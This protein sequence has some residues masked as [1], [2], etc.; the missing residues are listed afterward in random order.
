MSNNLTLGAASTVAGTP[1]TNKF[2]ET[3][4]TGQLV[5]QVTANIASVVLPVGAGSVY[6]PALLT[7]TGTYSNATVGVRVVGS[8]DPNRPPKLSDLVGVHWPVTRTGITGTVTLAGQYA[9]AD[10]TGT[11][12]NLR[13]YFYNGTD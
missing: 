8:P 3:N 7:T 5:K 11:E 4:G 9:D 13:G 12:T 10:I 1:G 6:R 2:V